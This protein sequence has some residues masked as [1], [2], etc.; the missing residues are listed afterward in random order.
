M[1]CVAIRNRNE[2]SWKRKNYQISTKYTFNLNAY[3]NS[4]YQNERV[5]MLNKLCSSFLGRRVT[6]KP[7]GLRLHDVMFQVHSFFDPMQNIVS[8]C[9]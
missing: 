7:Y 5:G 2:K 3:H 8:R 6:W 1:Y 4:I 9:V